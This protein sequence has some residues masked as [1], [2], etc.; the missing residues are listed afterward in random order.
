M[1]GIIIALAIVSFL[2]WALGRTRRSR[3]RRGGRDRVSREWL[4]SQDREEDRAGFEG[5]CWKWPARP[6]GG[7]GQL[8]LGL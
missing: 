2:L 5:V 3:R 6:S 8:S 4:S 1:P 7:G